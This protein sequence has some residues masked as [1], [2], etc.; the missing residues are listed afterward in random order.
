[1]T[2]QGFKRNK[3]EKNT[4]TPSLEKNENFIKLSREEALKENDR[5]LAINNSSIS[6]ASEIVAVLNNLTGNSADIQV[7]RNNKTIIF[8]VE[9]TSVVDSLGNESKL[10][11]IGLEMS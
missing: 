3:I 11:G 10:L 9:L 7:L 6:Y 2:L 1:M 4:D 5:I 8:P